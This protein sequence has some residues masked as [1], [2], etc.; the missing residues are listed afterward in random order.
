MDNKLLLLAAEEVKNAYK[1]PT[2][3]VKSTE[4][5]T[6]FTL[7]DGKLI[8]FIAIA[9]TNDITDWLWNIALVSWDGVKLASYYSAK[10]IIKRFERMPDYKLLVCGHSKSG[11]TAMYIGKKLKADYCVGFNPAPGFRKKE[12]L[13]NTCIVTDP[14]DIVH[15]MGRLNFNQPDCEKIEMPNDHRGIDLS[16]HSID[17]AIE[18][19]KQKVSI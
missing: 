5:N 13:A 19:F 4:W 6:G 11:P 12:K 10:R 3:N 16:D 14:D 9:G 2:H 15:K 17:N 8:Q 1:L 7:Y 18:Y